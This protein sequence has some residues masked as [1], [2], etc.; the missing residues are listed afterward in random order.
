MR[1][2]P[3]GPMIPDDLITDR[4]RGNVVFFCGAGVSLSSG[5]PT[6]G[7]LCKQVVQKL[8]APPTASSRI[9]LERHND[10]TAHNAGLPTYDSIFNV[11][12]Q[13]Y[14]A[15]EID[16]E[17]ARC[18]KPKHNT[19][20]KAHETVLRL[21]RSADGKYQI[22]TTNFDYLFEKAAK[23]RLNRFVPPTLPDL[24][25]GHS[26]NGLVYLH[27][28][29]DGRMRRR[30]VRQGFVI[31]SSDFGR[32]YLAEGWATNFVRDLLD[33]YTVVLLGYSANDPPVRYLL[34]GIHSR[35]QGHPPAIY[36][37]DDGNEE[38]VRQR[39]QDSGVLSL[40]YTK[41]DNEHSALWNTLNA[42]A[43]QADDPS[44][45]RMNVVDL[46]K[47][48]PRSLTPVQRGQVASILRTD[49]GAK[50]FADAN[51]PPPGEWLC[52]LDSQIRYAKATSEFDPL[53]EYGLDD[54][55]P[56]PLNSSHGNEWGKGEQGEDLLGLRAG[57]TQDTSQTRLAGIP[58]QWVDPLPDRLFHLSQWISH[59]AHE[60]VVAW[61]SVRYSS[62]H[63]K[64]IKQIEHR[65]MQ[66]D[67][68]LPTLARD[69][70][71][72]LIEMFQTATEDEFDNQWYK[73]LGRI[74]LEGWTPSVLRSFAHST[75]PYLTATI[76]NITTPAKPPETDWSEPNIE[77]IVRFE[78]KFP[79]HGQFDQ[80]NIPDTTVPYVYRIL[81]G[82]LEW[83][84]GLLSDID[85]AWWFTTTFY[86]E[87]R[88][89]EYV[90]INETS[91]YLHWFRSTLDR[92]IV[93]DPDLVMHDYA[94]WPREERFFFDK[95]RLYVWAIPG[96]ID[97][98][99]VADRLLT[100]S[101][102]A[103]W[104]FY[105]RRELL[106][107]LKARWVDFP[108]EDRVEIENRIANGPPIP[109][110]ENGE[111]GVRHQSIT[112]AAMLGWMKLH[113][114]TLTNATLQRI[115]DL[116]RV[117]PTWD[118]QWAE[119]AAS[120]NEGGGGWVQTE[121]D[122][123]S[124]IQ[125]PLNQI[126]PIALEETKAPIGELIN[127]SPFDG[128]VEVRPARAVAALTHAGRRGNYPSQ[129]W[130]SALQNWPDEVSCRLNRL[131]AERLARLPQ[132]L[133]FEL[134]F[135][136]FRWA[137][138]NLQVIARSDLEGA[139]QIFDVLVD[140]LFESPA[141]STQ[142]SIGAMNIRGEMI[143]RS[144]RTYAH[145]INSPVG[146][147]TQLLLKILND[148]K[149][150]KGDEIA[151][152]IRT[153]LEK[154]VTLPGV[155]GVVR[156]YAVCIITQDIMW[157]N[158]VDPGWITNTV[159]PWFN[160]DHELAEPAWNGY[161]HAPNT[162]PLPELFL[163]IKSNILD[164]VVRLQQ[165][166]WDDQVIRKAHGL[167]IRGC[168]EHQRDREYISFNEARVALQATNDA[169][170]VHCLSYLVRYVRSDKSQWQK[171]GKLFLERAWPRERIH[172]TGHTSNQF[173]QLAM[174]AGDLFPNIVDAVIPYLSSVSRLQSIWHLTRKDKGEEGAALA[175]K[176][177]QHTLKLLHALIPDALDY[178]PYELG[179]VLEM[180]GDTDSNL[181]QDSRWIHLH[182]IAIVW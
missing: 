40:A 3:D 56:R 142:S 151:E 154:L 81:R 130:R 139:I 158:Y 96:F 143:A 84:T 127:Y 33:R 113:G 92:L 44:A 102:K 87:D 156:D 150:G 125:L 141:E 47:Q 79:P 12:Q 39:W 172:Q 112:S 32:A 119:E 14:H 28:R 26:L 15:S 6:F 60:P 7:G 98:I 65:V 21:S 2:L 95:L 148:Q 90:F 94:L 41:T 17:I 160:V 93:L 163:Q 52:V 4:D 104:E 85:P 116:Q 99:V 24:A 109:E 89:S 153:R 48:G 9:M 91:S 75:Q 167:L 145:A 42:W 120:S 80:L 147:A 68:N 117:V 8:G 83:A 122:P 131:F 74:E 23:W 34:Q 135:E 78:V 121:T 5:M 159:V 128:L 22:V 25:S 35:K 64:L 181:R 177:P 155:P 45:W 124:I 182:Q 63:P 43:D 129:L 137:E 66:N 173:A 174:D 179:T 31:S 101:S 108:A 57:E 10:T 170:R 86:P 82:H 13:E 18:L 97:G 166:S 59:V 161:L 138:K 133:V 1:F 11:L 71:M 29:V 30:D 62:L 134:R 105:N 20:L 171:F 36:A 111:V 77:N 146:S 176:Y 50:L 73:T 49:V 106:M 152:P 72:L 100:L 165:W 149:P 61:W 132:W 19:S 126:I 27:G 103:F 180:I 136:V 164:M 157:L 54:H 115:V 140:K 76:P 88:S 58:D 123:S 16:Y 70:W 144:C 67:G 107:M 118:T 37:F 46:A 169:G 55:L 110:S 53:V 162:L 168:L 178:V 38:E 175:T 69:T 51:P 114:L